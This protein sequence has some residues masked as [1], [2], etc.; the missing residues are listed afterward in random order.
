[1]KKN[2][3]QI[4]APIM[5]VLFLA[6]MLIPVQEADAH[7]LGSNGYSTNGSGPPTTVQLSTCDPK[8]P[9]APCKAE[10]FGSITTNRSYQQTVTCGVNVTNYFGTLVARMW[11]NVTVTWGSSGYTI[12]SAYRNTWGAS[13]YGWTNL[14]GPSPSSGSYG[15]LQVTRVTVWGTATYLGVPFSSFQVRTNVTGRES[16]PSWRCSLY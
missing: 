5:V 9:Y 11:E 16:S 4:L 12:N 15:Y 10:L 14:S 13:G 6:L 7:D 3:F 8:N 1:M 2:T